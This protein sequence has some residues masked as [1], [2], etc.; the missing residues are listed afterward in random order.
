MELPLGNYPEEG[1]AGRGGSR[2][3][4][5]EHTSTKILLVRLPSAHSMLTNLHQGSHGLSLG[6][7]TEG[8][9][10][11]LWRSST[12]GVRKLGLQ[13]QLNHN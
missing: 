6:P 3:P 1:K 4:Q 13:A 11:A 5:R 12:R 2:C 9:W 10:K 8:D 7:E